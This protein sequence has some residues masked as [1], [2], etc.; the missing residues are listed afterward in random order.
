M[1]FQLYFQHFHLMY[2]NNNHFRDDFNCSKLTKN[3]QVIWDK[4]IKSYSEI[5]SELTETGQTY[6]NEHDFLCLVDGDN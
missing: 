6:M 3:E 2:K 4:C 1:K 5:T